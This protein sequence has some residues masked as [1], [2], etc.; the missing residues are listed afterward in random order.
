MATQ[1]Q[2]TKKEFLEALSKKGIT[3]LE[4]FVDTILPETGGYHQA[5]YFFEFDVPTGPFK[6][7]FT[8]DPDML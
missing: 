5:E 3:N 4:D 1:Q 7:T 2:P 8:W 6:I